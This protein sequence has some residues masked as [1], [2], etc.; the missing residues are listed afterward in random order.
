M[1]KILYL[2]AITL[3]GLS[4]SCTDM[5]KEDM[6]TQVTADY[7]YS[8]PDGVSR[9]VTGL[10]NYNRTLATV[11]TSYVFGVQ[12]LDV[13]TD[14]MIF[15]GGGMAALARLVNFQTDNALVLEFWMHNYNIIG[16]ANEVIYAAENLGIENSPITK[17]AWAEAKVFR[18]RSY[19][20]LFKRFDRLYLN[21]T[22]T[23]NT[24]LDREYSPAATEDVFKLINSDLEDAIGVLDWTVPTASTGTSYGRF[25]KAVAKHIKAQ[26]AMWQGNWDE[27][28]KQCEDIFECPAY[29]MLDDRAAVFAGA[30]LNHSETLWSLQFSKNIGGGG[31]V[32]EGSTLRGHR[33][34]LICTPRTTKVDGL[35]KFRA[36]NGGYGWG[37]AYPNTYLF[38][39]Y[40][41][42]K[43]NRYHAY[44]KHEWYYMDEDLL[45]EGKQLGD[46]ATTDKTGYLEQL[47][48]CSLKY[49]D[50]WTNADDPSRTSNFKDLIIYRLAETY[51]MAAEAY[52]H[53]EGGLSAKAIKYYNETWERAG[54][55]YFNGP[56][57]L[58][59]L[60]DEY[61]R[62]LHFEG[63]RWP[64]LKRLGL[65]EERVKLHAGDTMKENPKL[66]TD[67][68]HARKNFES[69]HWCWPIPQNEIDQMGIQDFPQN[70]GWN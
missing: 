51:L 28:I 11:E 23:D 42:K 52:F 58:D 67:Y 55:N 25:T 39:L 50:M 65:L 15:R 47:H 48:P 56:L 12:M 59:N 9:V 4:A 66:N 32:T 5:L 26:A 40:D 18:A 35:D 22:P 14:L 24:N 1:K 46:V 41:Q 29:A 19:F 34:S 49:F 54:N 68:N 3:L 6:K 16:K 63:V 10:Y 61:A 7:L 45:P 62:E 44:F 21:T 27:T 31:T 43:D 8:T 17:K 33:M 70:K 13:C 64:L 2:S 30:D 69:K 57:T 36:E 38:S 37:Y 53:K 20:E 60:L